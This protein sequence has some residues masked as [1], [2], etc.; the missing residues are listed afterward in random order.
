MDHLR[1]GGMGSQFCLR[2]IG[3]LVGGKAEVFMAP[4]VLLRGAMVYWRFNCANITARVSRHAATTITAW[5]ATC[6]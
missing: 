2:A 3:R 5:Y 1:P 4:S 6:C